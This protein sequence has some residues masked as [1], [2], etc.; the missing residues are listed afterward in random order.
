MSNRIIDLMTDYTNRN[1][2]GDQK[3]DRGVVI[4][5]RARGEGPF[6]VCPPSSRITPCRIA[7]GPTS[8]KRE[9]SNADNVG[10]VV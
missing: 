4:R 10:R 3:I 2:G 9:V 6:V 8:G 7:K 1:G 5:C